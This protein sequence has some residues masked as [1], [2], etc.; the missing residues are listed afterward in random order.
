MRDCT[1]WS[2]KRQLEWFRSQCAQHDELPFSDIL[3]EESVLEMLKPL[4]GRYYD[5]LCN[6]VVAIRG[7]LP[8]TIDA[9]RSLAAEV[10]EFLAWRLK[11]CLEIRTTALRSRRC[12]SRQLGSDGLGGPSYKTLAGP[13][14]ISKHVLSRPAM[15]KGGKPKLATFSSGHYWT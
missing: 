5:S 3:S 1:R 12:S 10:E 11:T 2:S 8:Q 15:K 14:R 6:P 4:G 9:D 13:K 7:F